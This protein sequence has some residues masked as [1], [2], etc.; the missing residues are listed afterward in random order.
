MNRYTYRRI[1]RRD[2]QGATWY[3]Y[4]LQGGSHTLI[5]EASPEE[6]ADW[7]VKQLNEQ[8]KQNGK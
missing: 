5:M 1:D 4:L 3:I 8:E 6:F 7:L 2:G